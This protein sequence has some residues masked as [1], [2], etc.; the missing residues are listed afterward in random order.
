MKIVNSFRFDSEKYGIVAVHVNSRAVRVTM[1]RKVGGLHFTVP[2]GIDEAQFREAFV[3]LTS[4]L[5]E[6][7]P[8][9]FYDEGLLVHNDLLTV[10]IARNPRV[11]SSKTFAARNRDSSF[12]IYVAPDCRL[13]SP[14]VTRSITMLLVRVAIAAAGQP[15][16]ARAEE[17]ARRCGASPRNWRMGR[18]LRTLGTCSAKGEITLSGALAFLPSHLRDYVICHELAHLS[19]MNH[20]SQFHELCN[21]YCLGRASGLERELKSFRW[22]LIR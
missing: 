14:D 5:G 12:T 8:Q 9:R 10:T 22:P 4:R 18:G 6:F 2:R 3:S 13:D 20:S 17:V 11:G 21:R 7:S 16:L 15:I 19:H 1:R